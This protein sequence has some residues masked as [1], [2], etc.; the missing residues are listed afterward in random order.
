MAKKKTSTKKIQTKP[1]LERFFEDDHHYNLLLNYVSGYDC[2]RYGCDQYCRC[3]IIDTSSFT[4]EESHFEHLMKAYWGKESLATQYAIERALNTCLNSIDSW[5]IQ[6]CEGYY[7]QEIGKCVIDYSVRRKLEGI[8]EQILKATTDSKKIEICLTAEYGYLLEGVK[9]AQFEV[10]SISTKKIVFGQLEYTKKL[11]KDIIYKY[12]YY[13]LPL[14]IVIPDGE[15]YRVVDGYHRLSGRID[16]G[17]KK[18]K[19]F[20]ALKGSI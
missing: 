13:S 10:V 4:M 20:E 11:S 15:K 17:K 5:D 3:G 9:D 19:V 2:E 8:L 6:V 16:A 14:G 18:V 12:Q 7:G 1:A